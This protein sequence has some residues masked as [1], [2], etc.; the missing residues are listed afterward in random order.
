MVING[1]YGTS[2]LT[3]SHKPNCLTL[4]LAN[5]SDNQVFSYDLEGR[6]WTAM[7]RGCSYRRGLNGKIV[8]K[9]IDPENLRQ[10][11]WLGPSE[12]AQLQVE[13]QAAAQNLLTAIQTG[14]A[15][16]DQ[17]LPPAAQASLQMAGQFDLSHYQADVHKFHQVYKPVGILPPDQYMALVL[18][19]TEGCSF[20]TCTFCNFYRDRPFH[21]KSPAA[22]QAHI[23]GV[24]EYLGAGLSLRRTIFLGDANALVVP[25]PRLE[26]LVNIIHEQLDVEALGGIYAFL[27]GF[28]GERKS[29]ADYRRLADRGL[30]RIYIG[31][32]SGNEDLLRFLK[33]PG[34]AADV[35]ASVQAIKAGGIALGL[36]VLLG[37]GGRQYARDHV[38]DTVRSLNA[39]HLDADDLVYFSELIESE[40]ME[41]TRDAYRAALSPLTSQERIAQGDEIEARLQFNSSNGTPHISRYDIREFVY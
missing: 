8:A 17:T 38:N 20:N 9:W 24:R 39:M 41:Y 2:H 19:V 34:K 14:Q 16:L 33:K 32:E 31:M 3:I 10:R 4:S 26:P 29:A 23:E 6:L 25:M 27:D 15:R 13:A 7:V 37:A 28:S 40:G 18:Q 11:K 1:K 12:T 21:I 5:T 35:I 30:K 22:L 36:I